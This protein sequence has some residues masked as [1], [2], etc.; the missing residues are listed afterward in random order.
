MPQCIAALLLFLYEPMKKCLSICISK[1]C[2]HTCQFIFVSLFV[3]GIPALLNFLMQK[4]ALFD[5]VEKDTD[6]LAF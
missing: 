3:F 2:K 5:Y 1:I 6:W 4:E